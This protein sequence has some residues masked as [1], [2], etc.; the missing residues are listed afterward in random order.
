MANKKGTKPAAASAPGPH[1]AKAQGEHPTGKA[2][3]PVQINL[4]DAL[5]KRVETL[6]ERGWFKSDV[7]RK[8]LDDCLKQKDGKD[9]T[10][11]VLPIDEVLRL[12]LLAFNWQEGKPYTFEFHWELLLKAG[13]VFAKAVG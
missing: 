4:G 10:P 3:K 7:L 5:H 1:A 12:C 2:Q 11:L 9:S 6:K 13:A 8:D